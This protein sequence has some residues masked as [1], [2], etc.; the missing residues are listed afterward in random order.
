MRSMDSIVQNHIITLD[1]LLSRG[2]GKEYGRGRLL[3][4]TGGRTEITVREILE[5][6]IPAMERLEIVFWPNILSS[7]LSLSA[8]CVFI[9]HVLPLWYAAYPSDDRIQRTIDIVRLYLK[10]EAGR[11]E[12]ARA[13]TH[14]CAAYD[15]NPEPALVEAD[16]ITTGW[17]VA[18][19]AICVLEAADELTEDYSPMMNYYISYCCFTAVQSDMIGKILKRDKIDWRTGSS[20]DI[21][22]VWDEAEAAAQVEFEWQAVTL[23]RMLLG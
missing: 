9:E 15:I 17:C 19:S 21:N 22:R 7:E 2:T 14:V 10:G 1:E 4:V 5:L 12:I 18:E 13:H 16:K 6:N 3:E 20:A 8:D 23:N 11:E